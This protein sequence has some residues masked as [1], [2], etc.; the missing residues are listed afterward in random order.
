MPIKVSGI[1]PSFT[2]GW[3][4]LPEVL[5]LQRLLSFIDTSMLR[6][7]GLGDPEHPMCTS[8]DRFESFL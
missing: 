4:R 6:K 8:C 5:L 1:T 2:V 7:P 3:F